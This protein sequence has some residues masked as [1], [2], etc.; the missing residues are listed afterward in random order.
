MPSSGR[1]VAACSE[2]LAHVAVLSLLDTIHRLHTTI[3][4]KDPLRLP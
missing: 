4:A 2:K 1:V 3:I